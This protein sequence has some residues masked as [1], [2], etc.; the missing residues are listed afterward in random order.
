MNHNNSIP[1]FSFPFFLGGVKNVTKIVLKSSQK[2]TEI[3]NL[4]CV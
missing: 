2:E 4:I 3:G 1:F